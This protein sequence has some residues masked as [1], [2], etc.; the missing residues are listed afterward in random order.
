MKMKC[1]RMNMTLLLLAALLAWCGA[2]FAQG[3]VDP[4]IPATGLGQSDSRSD[5]KSRPRHVAIQT[6]M[7]IVVIDG[8]P[9]LAQDGRLYAQGQQMGRSKIE[10]ITETEIWLRQGGRLR[11]ITFF[12]GVTR[13]VLA[14]ETTAC[15]SSSADESSITGRL[16][17]CGADPL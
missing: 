11:K 2:S 10:R 3:R 15:V 6:E 7:T 14:A 4:T 9:H 13:R 17:N 12:S 8:Q 16:T 5:A 1:E